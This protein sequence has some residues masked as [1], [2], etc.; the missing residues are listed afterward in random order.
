MSTLRD[1][2]TFPGL[3]ADLR[4]EA[5]WSQSRLG[6]EAG[7]DSSFICKLEAGDRQPSRQTVADLA[8]VL[9]C[10]PGDASRLF[11]AAGLLPPGRWVVLDDDADLLIRAAQE[12]SA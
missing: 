3:L 2:R 1:I 9:D 5:G 10:T 12:V 4:E 6:A 8:E 7:V 11:V